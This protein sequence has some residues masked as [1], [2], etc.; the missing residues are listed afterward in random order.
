MASTLRPVGHEDKLTLVEH[1]DELRNRLIVSIAVLIAVFG[2][3][4][5]QNNAILDF[6]NRPLEK[7]AFKQD[8]RTQDAFERTAAYQEAARRS[9]LRSARAHEELARLES[10]AAKAAQYRAIAA[11]DRAEAA[12][13]PPRQ[14]RRP[15]TTGVGEPFFETVRAAGYA[16]L[17]F[18]LPLLLY[19]AYAFVVP[20]FS[21][22]ER[23]VALPLM[24][25]SPFLFVAGAAFA[26]VIALPNA[27]NFLQ[28]FNDDNFD[29]LLQAKDYYRFSVLVLLAMGLLF[30]IPIAILALTRTEIVTTRQLRA[31]RRY[32]ILVI[33]ILAMLLPGTD[34]ITMLLCMAPL[35]VLYEGSILLAGLLDRRAA[36]A[37]AR[38]EAEM[39]AANDAELMPLDP[40]DED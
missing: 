10:N 34:P 17:L 12:K 20:A 37:A 2:I 6:L 19:Q 23:Q 18:S 39:A 13:I 26:Y 36:R 16:A 38:E 28:N 8:D 14:A 9:T 32:A 25:L 27:V 7:T 31:N 40:D 30:Q 4:F 15:I 29:I 11:A 1:L 33:A 24:L 21:P 35:L 5:W 3:C 22:R